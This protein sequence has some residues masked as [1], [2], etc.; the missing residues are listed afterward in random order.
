MADFQGFPRETL[1]FLESLRENNDKKWF[2]AH[3]DDYEQYFLAPA[4]EFVKAMGK[5]L[6]LIAPH[7]HADPRVNRSIFRIFRDTRFS[8]KKVPYKT[9]LALWFWEGRGKRMDC[10]GFY[11]HLDPQRVSLGCGMYRFPRA[12]LKAYREAFKDPEQASQLQS[13]VDA[14]EEKGYSAAGKHY[15]RMPRGFK[16]SHP[17]ADLLL[18]NG[19]YAGHEAKPGSAVHKPSFVDEAFQHYHAMLPLHRWLSDLD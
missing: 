16:A 15:K 1:T 17:Q 9:H 3:R 6:V 13:I 4:R 5:R 8:K 18:H 19:L 10:S 12:G 7:V 2:D 14:L 11:F